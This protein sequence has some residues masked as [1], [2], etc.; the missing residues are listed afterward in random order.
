MLDRGKGQFPLEFV[1]RCRIA[2]CRPSNDKWRTS[3]SSFT[4]MD[5]I[6]NNSP[7]RMRVADPE[8]LQERRKNR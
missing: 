5:L 7:N 1:W 3:N 8:Y 6:R 4:G 2:F